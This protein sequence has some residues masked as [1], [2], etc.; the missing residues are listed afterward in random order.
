MTDKYIINTS[1]NVPLELEIAGVGKRGMA[2]IIDGLILMAILLF[3]FFIIVASGRHYTLTEQLTVMAIYGAFVFAYHFFM[4][5]LTKGQSIGKKV[6]NI[7]VMQSDG[8][9][10]GLFQYLV[11]NLIRPVDTLH[12]LGLFPVF[13]T[14]NYQR[15]G[16]LAAG[17]IVVDQEEGRSSTHNT[18]LRMDRGKPK[19]PKYDRLKVMRLDIKDVELIQQVALRKKEHI[20]WHLI[21]L[22]TKKLEKKTG[23]SLEG[24]VNIDF[25]IQLENDYRY[26]H[27][28][29]T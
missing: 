20:N 17:T 18:L 23:I 12:N 16:D 25:L 10:P 27:Q 28:R 21:G 2:L 9:V 13:F 8:S 5:L 6:M 1:Q 14:A 7:R 29:T 19:E 3:V 22:L 24:T 4:E 26:Y 15:F 11:R